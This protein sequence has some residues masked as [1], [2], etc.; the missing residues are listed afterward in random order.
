MRNGLEEL[1][2][3]R[4]AHDH[5]TVVVSFGEGTQRVEIRMVR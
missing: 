2:S 4:A 3:V 5:S 1:S